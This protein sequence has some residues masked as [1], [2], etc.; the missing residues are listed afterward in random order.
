MTRVEPAYLAAE[1]CVKSKDDAW[2]TAQINGEKM[3]LLNASETN[4]V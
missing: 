4:T 3:L 1:H 2:I